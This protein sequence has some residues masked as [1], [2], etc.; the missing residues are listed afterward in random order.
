MCKQLV[1][2]SIHQSG[3]FVNPI[4]KDT[5]IG[6]LTCLRVVSTFDLQQPNDMKLPTFYLQWPLLLVLSTACLASCQKEGMIPATSTASLSKPDLTVGLPGILVAWTGGPAIPY[7]AYTPSDPPKT[8]LYSVGFTVN[9]KGF[10]LGGLIFTQSGETKHV[11]DLWEFDPAAAAWSRMSPFPGNYGGL[12]GESVFVVGDNAYVIQDST[13]WQYNQPT[14]HWTQKANF[15]G[16]AR[17]WGTG[18]SVNGNGYVGLGWSEVTDADVKD[19]W[20][21]DPATDHWTRM[22]DFGGAARN[23]AAGFAISGKAYVGL[24][25]GSGNYSTLWQYDPAANAWT[26]KHSLTGYSGYGGLSAAATI[27]GVNVGMLMGGAELYE[28]DPATDTWLNAGPEN[29]ITQGFSACFVIDH[30]FYVAGIQVK[31]YHWSR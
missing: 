12:V 21:Y 13:V 8:I 11:P 15:P 6:V 18:V 30:S 27:G 16:A 25:T 14:N 5:A 4:L 24:G 31:I 23:Q 9:G 17:L 28:Y 20:Q 1:C 26:Q 19:W 2:R 22:A 29:G 10:V 7:T 3:Y